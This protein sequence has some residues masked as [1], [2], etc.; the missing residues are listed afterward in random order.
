MRFALLLLACLSTLGSAAANDTILIKF[1]HVVAPD[2]PKGRAAEKF[3]ELA[4]KMSAGRVK[5]QLYPN[6]Q[7]YKDREE[8]A[9][10]QR[11]AVQILAPSLSKFGALGLRQFELF[12]LP[13]IF[14][15][16]KVLYRVMD[17]EIGQG[18][19]RQLNSKGIVGLAYW[20]NGFKHFSANRP[21]RTPADFKGL[22]M[23]IQ[24]SK[25]LEA[26]MKSLGAV[27]KVIAFSEVYSALQQQVIDGAENPESNFR[28]QRMHE[29]QKHLTLSQHGYVGYAVIVN[30]TFWEGLPTDLRAQ[31]STA[32][33]LATAYE[34]Q[35]ADE[36]NR[37]AL[38]EVR[39][40]HTTEIYV[41][42]LAD[43][44]ILRKQMLPVHREFLD[45]IGKDLIYGTYR[46]AAEVAAGK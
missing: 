18:L 14:P 45:I 33:Q 42:P 8:M 25:V 29:V 35:I 32:M 11:N 5:V 10:L 17:G 2:T 40:A 7:L 41:L 6:G 9:A 46:I 31:L 22:R 1:S 36:E 15:N 28:T 39:A 24:A 34:R 4:E 12:D 20:D 16:D 37:R 26:Q 44:E 43:R 13:Y 23:R 3:K 21:L 30:K 38:E 27:P 19:L